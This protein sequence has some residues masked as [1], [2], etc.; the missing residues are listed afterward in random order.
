V[1]HDIDVGIQGAVG[2]VEAPGG[3][4]LVAGSRRVGKVSFAAA[5][6]LTPDGSLDPSFGAGGVLVAGAEN[7]SFTCAI[8]LPD[9]ELVAA[10]QVPAHPLLARFPAR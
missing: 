7:S 8:A 5:A 2:L 1:L 9:G 6:R 10:G 3:G 4:I